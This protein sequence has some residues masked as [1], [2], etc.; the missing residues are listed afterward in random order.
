MSNVPPIFVINLARSIERRTHM[1]K[2]LDALDLKYEFIEAIDGEQLTDDQINEVYDEQLAIKYGGT[3]LPMGAIAT[4]MSH[5]KALQTII[6]RNIPEAL[7]LE[8]DIIVSPDIKPFFEQ[9]NKLPRDYG[10]LSLSVRNDSNQEIFFW[11]RKSWKIYKDYIVGLPSGWLCGAYAYLIQD[12]Y[13]REFMQCMYPILCQYD[14]RCFHTSFTH[15]IYYAFKNKSI[16]ETKEIFPSDRLSDKN[17][18]IVIRD[19]SIISQ[20]KNI[21]KIP[22]KPGIF[23]VMFYQLKRI[24]FTI[25]K[26]SLV[27]W[28]LPKRFPNRIIRYYKDTHRSRGAILRY[29]YNLHVK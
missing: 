12:S 11:Y 3:I 29:F 24:I 18:R 7:I 2:M 6:D 5:V 22:S 17:K 1:S 25:I 9:R 10:I 23:N 14:T 19:K 27:Y 15:N 4:Y 26:Y 13:I 28:F 8:D 21:Q 16:I 20:I